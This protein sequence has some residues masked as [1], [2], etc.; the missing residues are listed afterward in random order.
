VNLGQAHC[1]ASQAL[2]LDLPLENNSSIMF[3]NYGFIWI[4]RF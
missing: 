1:L 3:I 2:T 4:R